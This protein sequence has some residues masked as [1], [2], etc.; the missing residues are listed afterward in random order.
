MCLLP[1]WKLSSEIR[2]RC[3]L[4]IRIAMAPREASGSPLSS[5]TPGECSQRACFVPQLGERGESTSFVISLETT[6]TCRESLGVCSPEELFL[7]APSIC[8]SDHPSHLVI[9]RKCTSSQVS[10]YS[11]TS[12][13]ESDCSTFWNSVGPMPPHSLT[14][15]SHFLAA[16]VSLCH[17]ESVVHC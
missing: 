3:C 14:Y 2:S 11:S 1:V 7:T 4:P 5:W 8:Y 16:P 9:S 17:P 13:L 12:C 6:V 15:M 10:P